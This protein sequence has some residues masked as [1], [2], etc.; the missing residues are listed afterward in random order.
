M[1]VK[2]YTEGVPAVFY[3]LAVDQCACVTVEGAAVICAA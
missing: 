1:R 2:Q 3:A